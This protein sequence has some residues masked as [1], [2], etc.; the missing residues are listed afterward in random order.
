MNVPYGLLCQTLQQRRLDKLPA[1]TLT[2]G[3]WKDNKNEVNLNTAK[4]INQTYT[5]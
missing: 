1:Q 5:P 2:E 3:Y 4:N